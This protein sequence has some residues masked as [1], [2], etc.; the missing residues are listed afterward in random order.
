MDIGVPHGTPI[1]AVKDGKVVFAGDGG[2]YGNLT[3]IQ[4]DDGTFTKYAHQSEINVQAGQ[5]VKAGDVI[6]KVG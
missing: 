1:Q 5:E 2:G 4:H 3:V 6:G